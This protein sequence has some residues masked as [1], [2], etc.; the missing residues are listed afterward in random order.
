VSHAASPL[1]RFR[2]SSNRFLASLIFGLS[3]LLPACVAAP[4]DA[5]HFSR[6]HPLSQRSEQGLIDATV[7]LETA[8][9][10]RGRNDLRVTLRATEGAAS[11]SADAP[12]LTGVEAVMAAHGHRAAQ[13][14]IVSDTDGAFRVEQLDLF[15]SGRWQVTLVVEL[16]ARSDS[17]D[18]ALDVP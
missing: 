4:D 11:A 17:V 1:R 9:L 16:D 13:P 10:T 12:R 15:M 6:E 14:S 18:F 3:L 2:R 5:A 7:A 8:E